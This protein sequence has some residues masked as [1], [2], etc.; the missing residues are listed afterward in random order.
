MILI[1]TILTLGF[2]PILSHILV[3]HFALLD[4]SFP[5]KT[6]VAVEFSIYKFHWLFIAT[7]VIVILA[8]LACFH[9]SKPIKF[10]TD[11]AES[12]NLLSFLLK[13][14]DIGYFIVF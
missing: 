11:F 12:E 1:V 2:S 9:A 7:F 10:V 4:G 8:G 14:I 3:A 6:V 13:S 5:I